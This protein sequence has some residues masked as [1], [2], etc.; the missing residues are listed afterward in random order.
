MAIAQTEIDEENEIKVIFLVSVNNEKTKFKIHKNDV[1]DV[2]SHDI[3]TTL[4]NPS[5]TLIGSRIYYEFP[6]YI[7]VLEEA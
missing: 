4:V 2:H 5:I 6:N 1:V 7:D 3:I